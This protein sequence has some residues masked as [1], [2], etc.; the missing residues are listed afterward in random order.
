MIYYH[1]QSYFASLLDICVN[2][3]KVN[4]MYPNIQHSKISLHFLYISAN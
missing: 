2:L 1:L 3:D 4:K